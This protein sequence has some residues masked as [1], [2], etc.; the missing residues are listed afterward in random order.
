[1]AEMVNRPNPPPPQPP[2]RRG[3]KGRADSFSSL[4]PCLSV[5]N[6]LRGKQ[7]TENLAR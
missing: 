2:R 3:G 4:I 7:R 5:F 1:M 6:R